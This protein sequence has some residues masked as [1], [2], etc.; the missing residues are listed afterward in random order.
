MA[1]ID[2]KK[3]IK[4]SIISLLILL[5]LIILVYFEQKEKKDHITYSSFEEILNNRD[6]VTY[7]KSKYIREEESN[8]IPFQTDIYL[9]F[10]KPLFNGE[11]SNE[12]YYSNMVEIIAI[13]N[14][15]RSFRLIDEENSIVVAVICNHNNQ[16][17]E[18]IV[19]NNDPA[20]YT[21]M[22]SNKALKEYKKTKITELDIQSQLINNLVK[23]NWMINNLNLNLDDNYETE[24]GYKY[25]INEKIEVKMIKDKVFNIVFDMEYKEN[26]VDGLNVESS[27]EDIIKKLGSPT[28]GSVEDKYIGYKGK[29]IYIFFT[30]GQVSVYSINQNKEEN[31]EKA[32]NEYIEQKDLKKFISSITDIW[33]DYDNYNYTENMIDLSYVNKGVKIQYSV[34]ERHGITFYNNY[35]GTVINNKTLEELSKEDI[36]IP[37]FI[38]FIDKDSIDE[39]ESGRSQLYLLSIYGDEE[40]VEDYN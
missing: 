17:I 11:E 8:I 26:I 34:T 19:I 39:Y 12:S 1:N 10:S 9:T 24:N 15:Y 37:R 16:E 3:I 25:Y 23:N 7:M 32:I 31:V 18:Q 5:L 29:E 40:F 6:G 35:I 30:E 33:E 13:V 21:R 2:K 36:E 14:S 38:Y 20:Y 28:F 22:K 4:I 27:F